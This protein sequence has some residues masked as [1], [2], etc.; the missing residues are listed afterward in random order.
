[1]ANMETYTMTNTGTVNLPIS[2]YKQLIQDAHDFKMLMNLLIQNM[3]RDD[4]H[5]GYSVY[6]IEDVITPFENKEDNE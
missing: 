6:N 5:H 2:E 1:M 4:Y 3:V